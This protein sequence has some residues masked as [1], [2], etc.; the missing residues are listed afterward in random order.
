MQKDQ[1]R[2]NVTNKSD[3]TISKEKMSKYDD[4]IN[5]P[6]HVSSKRKPMSMMNRAAQ[7]APFA[8]LTGHSE[9]INETARITSARQN[10]SDEDLSR[11]SRKLAYA[12]SHASVTPVMTFTCFVPD[13]LKSGG[14]YIEIHGIVKRL[15]EHSR[16]L[17]LHDGTKISLDDISDVN[18][19]LFNNLE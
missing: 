14:E 9:A 8:A 18:S 10:L 2:G 4:I 11:L 6:H 13:K 5:L 19:P 12:L 3:D 17:H 15:D 16:I 7:F 1:H